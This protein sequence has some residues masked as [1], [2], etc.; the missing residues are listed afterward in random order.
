MH[1]WGSGLVLWVSGLIFRVSA[2]HLSLWTC[3]LDWICTLFFLQVALGSRGSHDL[4]QGP[5]CGLAAV[6]EC[7]LNFCVQAADIVGVTSAPTTRNGGL[8]HLRQQKHAEF[9]TSVF[10]H[11]YGSQRAPDYQWDASREAVARVE[12]GRDAG[13]GS[14]ISFIYL[15]CCLSLKLAI[16]NTDM[17]S[18]TAYGKR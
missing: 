7:S 3:T 8:L 16:S 5:R 15:V 13:T 6:A 4:V 17:C 2:L 9:F 18:T 11:N 12:A 10:K 14:R 1:L